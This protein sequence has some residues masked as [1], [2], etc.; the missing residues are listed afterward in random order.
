[1]QALLFLLTAFYTHSKA[2]I[3]KGENY[4][5]YQRC[6][7]RNFHWKNQHALHPEIVVAVVVGG[8]GGGGGGGGVVV[9]VFTLNRR[10]YPAS[11]VHPVSVLIPY[12]DEILILWSQTVRQRKTKNK[13]ESQIPVSSK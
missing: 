13:T 4:S 7:V 12:P 9:V 6:V 1:M 8:G 11:S 10:F 3:Q 2:S 5:L